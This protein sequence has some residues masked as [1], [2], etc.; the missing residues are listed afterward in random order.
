[1]RQDMTPPKS[2]TNINRQ[3]KLNGLYT[4]G[5]PMTTQVANVLKVQIE[6]DTGSG[7]I[8]DRANMNYPAAYAA[9]VEGINDQNKVR[10][11]A[12]DH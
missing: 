10:T 9:I 2:E 7:T 3:N 11:L 4:T 1:M 12:F 6:S 8:L 5:N